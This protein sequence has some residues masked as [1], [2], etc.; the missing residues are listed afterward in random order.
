MPESDIA[1]D[2][3]S[4]RQEGHLHVVGFY[5][6]DLPKLSA[7]LRFPLFSEDEQREIQRV[8]DKVNPPGMARF[9]TMGLLY[10]TD[11]RGSLHVPI[12]YGDRD[13]RRRVQAS[14]LGKTVQRGTVEQGSEA[15]GHQKGARPSDSAVRCEKCLSNVIVACGLSSLFIWVLAT[16]ASSSRNSTLNQWPSGC[17]RLCLCRLHA[18]RQSHG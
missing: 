1:V 18:L 14:S 4:R 15:T 2:P 16:A 13:G 3:V 7:L 11:Y 10:R 17:L 5:Y 9:S 12:P 6:R 8:F